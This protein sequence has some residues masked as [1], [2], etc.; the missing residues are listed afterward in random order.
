MWLFLP[1]VH[2]QKRCDFYFFFLYGQIANKGN[3]FP[4]KS[5]G[6][7]TPDPKAVLLGESS[8][9]SLGI[10]QGK[11]F[12]PCGYFRLTIALYLLS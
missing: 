6:D 8:H 12:S 2:H 10:G 4:V 1:S 7:E 9:G 3:C 11:W 5:G